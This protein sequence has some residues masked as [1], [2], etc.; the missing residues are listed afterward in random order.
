[1]IADKEILA[2]A[3]IGFEAQRAKVDEKIRDLRATLGLQSPGRPKKISGPAI[4]TSPRK[5][6]KRELSPEAREKMAA[7]QRK[8]WA[9]FHKAKNTAK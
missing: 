3:L 5:R 7:A 2:A 8:R 9:A 6:T 4:P 1:M